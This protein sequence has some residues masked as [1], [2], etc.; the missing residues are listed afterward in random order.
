LIQPSI[1]KLCEALWDKEGYHIFV[2]TGHSGSQSDGQI[3]WIEVNEQDSLSVEEFKYAL[4]EAIDRGLQLAIFNSCDGLGLA[5]QL[6]QLNLPRSIVMREPVPDEVAVEFLEHFFAAFTDS[7][8]GIHSLFTSIHQARKKLEHFS[9]QQESRKFYPGVMWLP[10]LCM[11]QSAL[12][13][14]FTWKDLVKTSLLR[15]PLLW[16]F[17]AAGVG[18]SI[19]LAIGGHEDFSREKIFSLGLP[20]LASIKQSLLSLIKPP[21][22]GRWNYGGSTTWAPI[23]AQVQSWIQ[24][25]YPEFDLI[26]TQ[27][28]TEPPGSG[29]GIVMLLEGRLSFAESSRPL[30]NKEYEEAKLR[31]FELVQIPVAIDNI[32]VVV[33]PSLNIKGL[34]LDQLKGIYTGQITNWQQIGGPDLKIVPISRPALAGG[35]PEFFKDNVLGQQ[36]FG[37]NVLYEDETT[38][39][40]R[41]VGHA[42]STDGIPGSIYYG[43][44]PEL[45][46]Q[47]TVKPLPIA[48]GSGSGFVAPFGGKL[49]PPENCPDQRN[50]LNT[51]A[52]REEQYPLSRRLF[53]IVK[54]DGG[55]DQQAGE[56]YVRLL[57][58]SKGQKLIEAAGFVP[59]HP[60]P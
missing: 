54:R 56:A 60:M 14:P 41:R 53:V 15:Q 30:S 50:Q 33:H 39:A 5:N 23:R 3:G 25:T 42:A 8:A 26:Y 57:R 34:T 45:V 52:F 44:A 18:L 22:A 58:S 2:F 28:S 12:E 40:L 49:V 43:S 35:T 27:H 46:G 29:T 48:R 7:N 17:I 24:P 11:R 6:A 31:G 13:Q 51:E 37:K 19:G 10:V 47:C 20:P 21:P 9:V 16:S 4:R 38:T 1:R 55:E 36:D 32:A 59:L